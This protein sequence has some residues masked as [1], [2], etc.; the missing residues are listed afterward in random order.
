MKIAIRVLVAVFAIWCLSG[1]ATIAAHNAETNKWQALVDQVTERYHARHVYIRVQAG[2]AGVYHCENSTLELGTNGTNP[3]GLLAHE[4]GHAVLGHCGANY[5][6][7]LDANAF[8][9]EALKIWGDSQ[10]TAV[11]DTVLHLLK[12]ARSSYRSPVHNFCAEAADVLRRYPTEPDPRDPG[13][14]TCQMEIAL[15][16]PAQKAGS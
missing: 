6:Q 5:Q 7:E 3:R 14:M 12:V 2:T 15:V 16:R 10:A 4:L 8:A 1:C 9:V 11:R 13:D